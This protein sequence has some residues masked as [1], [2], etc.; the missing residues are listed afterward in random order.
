MS[1]SHRRRSSVCVAFALVAV[2]ALASA[3]TASAALTYFTVNGIR[4]VDNGSWVYVQG[5]DGACPASVVIL[6]TVNSKAVES[7]DN[8]AFWISI[9]SSNDASALKS[10]TIPASVSSI[11]TSAFQGSNVETVTFEANSTLQMFGMYAFKAAT[12]LE[13]ITVPKS[14]VEI[15]DQAFY[16][17]G[18][19]TVTFEA[20]SGLKR[21]LASGF[22]SALALKT[23]TL[24]DAVNYLGTDVFSGDTSLESFTI[25]SSLTTIPAN[26]F[27]GN[28][29]LASVS[30]PAGVTSIGASAFQGAANLDLVTFLGNAPSVG[31]DAFT[32][33]KARAK[34]YRAGNLTGFGNAGTLFHGLVV[35]GPPNNITVAKA[36]NK[37]A[38]ALITL[39]TSV[40]VPGAGKLT[41]VVTSKVGRKTTTWC[42]SKATPTTAGA[43]TLTCRITKAGRKALSK[44]AMKLTV[45]TSFTPTGGLKAT[46][47]QLTKL[48]RTR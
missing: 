11:G 25:P 5:C 24:P 3:G 30:I 38:K 39:T 1:K 17:S 14:V 27:K 41:Q 32:G 13:G 48:K 19:K 2:S 35:T 33:V 8:F 4:Y 46:K 44:A 42:T 12:K 26:T 43:Y 47:T 31:T 18:L 34:A 29:S 20:G 15:Q 36:R 28:T 10:I 21:V 37:I 7:I 22:A 9:Y 23:I 40:T 6:D 45:T 16:G